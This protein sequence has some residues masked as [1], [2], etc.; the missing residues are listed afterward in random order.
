M[1]KYIPPPGY[2]C[3]ASCRKVSSCG[4]LPLEPSLLP[5]GSGPPWPELT[6]IPPLSGRRW[7]RP[8][9]GCPR[10]VQ[11]APP[12]RPRRAAARS[13]AR[14]LA[15]SWLLGIALE[16]AAV[17]PATKI[18]WF[19][20]QSIGGYPRP[21]P[22]L[23][24][25]R[26]RLSRPLADPPQ[27][28]LLSTPCRSSACWP[29][30]STCAAAC[31]AGC[32]VGPDGS[33]VAA[34]AT[35]AALAWPMG[36]AW[37]LAQHRC[38]A[39]AVRPLAAAS[40]ARGADAVG[41]RLA[42][43]ACTWSMSLICP[44]RSRSIL[45]S[46]AS[47]LVLRPCTPSPCSAFASSTRCRPRAPRPFEQMREGMVVFDPHWRVA[48]LNPAAES[49]LGVRRRAPAGR[50][51][52]QLAP[53]SRQPE[54]PRLPAAPDEPFEIRASAGAGDRTY[55]IDALPA[56]RLS[57]AARWATCS[58]CGMSPSSN[59]AAGA[60][61]RAAA[62]AG[63]APRARATGPRAARRHRPG[64]R[65]SRACNSAW[66]TTHHAGQQRSQPGKADEPTCGRDQLRVAVVEEAHAD[67]REYILNLRTA[68]CRGATVLC[69]PAALPRRLQPEL[70][71]PDRVIDRAGRRRAHCSTRRRRCSCSASSRRP[72]Q[73]AQARRA[74]PRAGVLRALEDGLLRMQR[75][76][77]RLRV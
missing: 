12:R 32:E 70:R 69:D 14:S 59:G 22:P 41:H 52:Q 62:V 29:S 40:L 7:R 45:S 26:V 9:S 77:R 53:A 8:S 74:E 64:A 42:A 15:A 76:G 66:C 1:R 56:P 47:L 30:S 17:A 58:C 31:G 67:V 73:R 36:S 38:L 5:Q 55:E 37:S 20:F 23:L 50:D 25:P 10:P 48:S 3:T 19:R 13:S 60:D 57:R 65:L 35:A 39:L 6:S 72:F 16:A 27:P 63:H 24:C 61:H 75:P 68:P 71:Y 33:V 11:L 46:S 21:P 34:F 18:A 28:G 4:T 49:I 43:A 54:Q 44:G 2:P 51:P